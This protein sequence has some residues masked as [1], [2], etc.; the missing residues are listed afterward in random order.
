MNFAV[1]T[2]IVIKRAHCTYKKQRYSRTDKIE[3]VICR[4]KAQYTCLFLAV[5]GIQN[6]LA[7][8]ARKRVVSFHEG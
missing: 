1:I 2:N 4:V 6:L 8:M 7:K 3:S 5:N